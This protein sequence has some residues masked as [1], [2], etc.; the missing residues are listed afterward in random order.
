MIL[1]FESYLK[2]ILEESH[3]CCDETD[4]VG[5][6]HG[7]DE[8]PPHIV[9]AGGDATV[10]GGRG[11][12]QQCCNTLQHK[13]QHLHYKQYTTQHAIPATQHLQCKQFL[14]IKVTYCRH[15]HVMTCAIQATSCGA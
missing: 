3:R 9:G 7:L 14:E 13:A 12:P 5:I 4:H 2:A 8:L 6:T 1:C 10:Q 11:Y 15:K